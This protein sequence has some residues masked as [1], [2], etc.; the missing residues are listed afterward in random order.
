MFVRKHAEA[1]NLYCDVTVLYVYPD[2]N[3]DAFEIIEQKHNDLREIIVYYPFN[4]KNIFYKIFK[5][6]NY[7][8]AY[9]K[10]YEYIV[11]QGFSP[12]I[13]QVNVL[14]RTGVMAYLHKLWKG[15]PYTIIEHW[16]RYLP[17]RREYS[18]FIR[19]KMTE[20]VV[21]HAA[22][23]LPVSANLRESMLNHKLYNP[24]YV[25]INN[26]VDDSFLEK[27]EIYPRTK[28]RILHVSRFD[29]RAKNITGLLRVISELSKMRNDFEVVIIGREFDKVL[30]YAR[31]LELPQETV[32]FLGRK[33][34]PGEMAEWFN[35]CDFFVMFSNYENAPVVIMESLI[36]GKP[37]VSTDV[38][39]IP[40]HVN[41][42]NGILVPAKDEAGLLKSLNYMLD[43]FQ[44]YD[45]EKIK[46]EAREKYTYS[47]VGKELADIY[48][49]ILK[50]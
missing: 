1:V 22:A 7:V 46:Q 41:D 10:G 38:G 37:V 15:T 30:A 42:T 31:T 6:I 44:Q 43:N 11:R 29:D 24:N 32:S 48:S 14:T 27:K 25:V 50:R 40:E 49:Q 33:S 45:S 18:G 13:V 8:R 2:E 28:K 47:K 9:R 12:D 16:S 26:V 17:I 4:T 20:K 19:K 36:S 34:A 39:G 21:K 3:I 23:V 35:N 5:T